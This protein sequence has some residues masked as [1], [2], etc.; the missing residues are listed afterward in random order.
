MDVPPILDKIAHCES[1]GRQFDVTGKVIQGRIDPDDRG[2]YQINRRYH[3]A[4][5]TS[6]G[7]DLETTEGNT[8]YALLLYKENGTKDW[9]ASKACWNNS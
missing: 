3:L 6:L 7:L 2:K 1:G 8:A 5:A 4:R 9:L